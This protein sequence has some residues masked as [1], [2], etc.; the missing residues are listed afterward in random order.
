MIAEPNLRSTPAF[1]VG[2]PV[3]FVNS[4]FTFVT[5]SALFQEKLK[6]GSFVLL[7]ASLLFLIFLSCT[8]IAI[9]YYSDNNQ[10]RKE[11]R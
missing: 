1:V 6:P 10:K 3:A 9:H 11:S 2:M 5:P 8:D 4:R 7:I